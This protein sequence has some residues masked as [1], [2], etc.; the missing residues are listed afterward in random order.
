VN[1]ASEQV[2]V[3]PRLSGTSLRAVSALVL[4]V[5]A[6]ASV[7]FGPPWFTA[8]ILLAAVLMAW[9]W[10]RMCAARPLWLI[11]GAFYISIPCGA[12]IWLR[13]D[14]T[15]GMITILWIFAIVWCADIAAYLS[16]RA[17]GGPKLAPSISPKKTWAGFIGGVSFASIVGGAFALYW[18]GSPLSLALWAGIV[19]I[20][21]QAGDLLESAV[22]RH[23][24]V[25]DSS[26]LIPGHGG[27]LDRVDAL[28]TGS[29]A[30][31]LMKMAIGK[32]VM[33]WL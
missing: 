22:K 18:D 7:Y 13:D 8:L 2:T 30:V 28:I 26:A 1:A 29:V 6:L 31:A 14:S 5:P 16:G 9:E 17:I 12:L 32:G 33:P 11:A 15:P 20:A 21:S 19:A 4:A 25:K 24:G 3:K 27:V 23:F 10:T